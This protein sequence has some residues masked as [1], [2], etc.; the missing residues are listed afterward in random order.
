MPTTLTT[1]GTIAVACKNCVHS[2]MRPTPL[3]CHPNCTFTFTDYHSGLTQVVQ[4]S[5]QAARTVGPCGPSAT[6][7]QAKP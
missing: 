1:Y 3:C 4:M 6:L 2:E 7:F 5:D